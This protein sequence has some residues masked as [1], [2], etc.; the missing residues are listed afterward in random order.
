[1]RLRECL[2]NTEFADK[3]KNSQNGH[4]Y[5]K[6][7]KEQIVDELGISTAAKASDFTAAKIF[8]DNT[9]PTFN[10]EGRYNLSDISNTKQV[11]VDQLIGQEQTTLDRVL[12]DYFTNKR[13]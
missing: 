11:G 8:L 5:L 1:L 10:V 9:D 12:A 7:L 13:G 2:L 6:V 3:V 4:I